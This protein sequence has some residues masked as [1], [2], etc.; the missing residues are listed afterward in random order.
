[1][2]ITKNTT[3]AA[4]RAAF[5]D[6]ELPS[7]ERKDVTPEEAVQIRESK[8]AKITQ[9][10]SRG[11][12]NDKLEGILKNATP[13]GRVGKFVRDRPEDI[14]RYENLGY[15]FDV[16]PGATGLH[17]TGDTRVRV[18]DVVLMTISVDDFE[19]LREINARTVRQKLGVARK[20]YHNL[21]ES[22]S[23]LAMPAFDESHTIIG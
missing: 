4:I 22:R 17:G 8:I 7:T 12:L 6:D 2:A 23:D 3:P 19:L 13:A 1:M 21:T 10:L 5:A 9:V 16:K 15:T 18:G 20:E 14:M 11:L